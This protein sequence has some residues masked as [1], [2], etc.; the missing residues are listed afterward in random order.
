MIETTESNC[1][2]FMVIVWKKILSRHSAF[3]DC[4]NVC[5]FTFQ[6]ITFCVKFASFC[7]W[8]WSVLLRLHCKLWDAFSITNMRCFPGPFRLRAELN[9][10]KQFWMQNFPRLT[11]CQFFRKNRKLKFLFYF[12]V[13][14]LVGN[15]LISFN[16]RQGLSSQIYPDLW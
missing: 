9:R 14:N 6:P 12:H 8:Y 10:H 3:Q 4:L 15:I 2:L 13:F 5:F 1:V 7:N 16:S 11:F